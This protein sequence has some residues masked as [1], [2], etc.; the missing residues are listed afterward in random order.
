MYKWIWIWSQVTVVM[1]TDTITDT[2]VTFCRDRRES[3]LSG[4]ITTVTASI[5]T[6][7]SFLYVRSAYLRH[8]A[9]RRSRKGEPD[10]YHQSRAVSEWRPTN[11][12]NKFESRC[13]C[14]RGRRGLSAFFASA[15]AHASTRRG[16]TGVR[17]RRCDGRKLEVFLWW[18]RS[19]WKKD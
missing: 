19:R 18:N 6:T 3:P 2:F 1:I 8:L 7:I 12:I 13:W 14:A 17:S 16:Y 9:L 15:S 10:W 11:A 5:D 4:I